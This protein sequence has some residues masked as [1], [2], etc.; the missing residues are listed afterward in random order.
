[1]STLPQKAK[2]VVIGAGIV[3][4]SL[5]YHL[6]KLGWTDM[7]QID[8][9]PLPN[10]G[11]STGHASNF[12]FPVDHSK[13]MCKLTQDSVQTYI[14]LGTYTMSGGIE[15][16]RTDG[17]MQE[18]QRRISSAK[19]WGEPGEMITPEQIKEMA[20]F[21]NTDD[22]K[23]GFYSPT[24]GVVDSLQAGNLMRQYATDKG[25]LSVHSQVEVI[26]IHVED[27][28]VKRV[29]TTEGTIETEYVL[30]ATGVWSPLLGKMTGVHIPLAPIVHQF[31]TVG[32]I[33]IFE[34]TEGEINFH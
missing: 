15:L 11:G 27:G 5:V 3:G 6:A 33:S 23:G 1:M 10:P 18:I 32:P 16:A 21:V 30:I 17:R 4:N 25:A 20:P 22:I 31:S 34:E 24:A 8:K 12:I 9:G 7:V 13:E 29:E 2:V 28:V 26:D 14:D 19:A